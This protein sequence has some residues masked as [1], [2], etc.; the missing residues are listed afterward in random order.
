MFNPIDVS[1]ATINRKDG[2]IGDGGSYCFTNMKII[3]WQNSHEITLSH[4]LPSAK[5][6]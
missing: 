5:P 1:K 4:G 2:K 6:A 3:W